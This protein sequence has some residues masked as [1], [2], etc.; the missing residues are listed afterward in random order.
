MKMSLALIAFALIGLGF[1]QSADN[2]LS[3]VNLQVNPNTVVAGQNVTITFL[4]YDSYTQTLQNVNLQLQGSYPILNYSPAYS[5]LISS[6]GQGVYGGLNNYFTYKIHVPEDT[7]SGYY[8]LDVVATYQ[9]VTTGAT[10]TTVTSQSTMPIS[11]YVNGVPYVGLNAASTS[12]SPGGQTSVTLTAINSGYGDAKNLTLEL[13]GTNEFK[14]IGSKELYIG[15]LSSGSSS[16]TQA[17]YYTASNITNATYYIPVLATYRSVG[18]KL[19]NQTLNA[20]LSVVIQNPNIVVKPS[21]TTPQSL[22]AGYNQTIGLVIENIGTGEAKNVTV[23]LGSGALSLMSSVSNFF[24]GSLE[25]GSSE[26]EYVIVSANSTENPALIANTSYYSSNYGSFVQ[27]N[28]PINLTVA[29]AALFTI[30]NGKYYLSPGSTNVPVRLTITNT[31]TEVA[32]QVQVSI[33][34]IYPVTPVQSTYYIPSIAPGQSANMTF[35]VSADPHG[36]SGTYP[37]TLFEQWKQPNGAPN[38]LYSGS[39]SYFV[40]VGGTAGS[41]ST[42]IVIGVIVVVIIVIGARFIMK[43]KKPIKKG[44]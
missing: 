36:I 44:K 12:V 30:G 11:F 39:S 34:T 26:T 13:L 28:I 14:P 42:P 5:N 22:Y 4:I 10:S 37:V 18:N 6:M 27:K 19:V 3:I 31:G 1:A 7:P 40:T 35:L 38:Q 21:S 15:T 25:P 20:S 8:T 41:D 32:N 43:K 9:T 2:A 24:I 29:P 23:K 16:S 17:T 33:D